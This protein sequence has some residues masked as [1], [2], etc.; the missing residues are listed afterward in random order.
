M[1]IPLCK[2]RADLSVYR[3]GDITNILYYLRSEA[4]SG[5]FIHRIVFST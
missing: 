5:D 4:G 3:K 1:V 2:D